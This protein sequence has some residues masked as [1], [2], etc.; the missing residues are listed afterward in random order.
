MKAKVTRT[1]WDLDPANRSLRTEIDIE[2]PDLLLRPGMFATVTILLAERADVLTLPV[3]AI[4]RDG[5]D[6]FCCQVVSSRI[7]RTP[8][9]LGLRSGKEIEVLSGLAG[10]ESVVLLRADALKDG[11]PVETASSPQK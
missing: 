1:S 7:Q 8:L 6:S 4:V 10:D 3:T 9:I 11:E 5:Q 2:N